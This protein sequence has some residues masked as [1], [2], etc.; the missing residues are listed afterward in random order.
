MDLY[1]QFIQYEEQFVGYPI[2]E[3]AYRH[4]ELPVFAVVLYL[5]F[6]FAGPDM[7][8]GFKPLK[9]KYAFA[10]WNLG[11]A[12]FSIVGVTRTVPVLYRAL[13]AHGLRYT[14]CENPLNW[15]GK[16]PVA[17]WIGGFIFSKFPELL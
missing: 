13:Q 8:K 17:V 15:C 4:S 10:L 14:C 12:L 5:G 2:L 6:I 7:L 9:L 3:F 1:R 16:G 11:L